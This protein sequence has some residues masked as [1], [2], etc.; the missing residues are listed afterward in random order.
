VI[1]AAARSSVDFMKGKG[2]EMKMTLKTCLRKGKCSAPLSW[3]QRGNTTEEE[4]REERKKKKK[5]HRRR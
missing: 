2:E 3:G 4:E 5:R 1:V